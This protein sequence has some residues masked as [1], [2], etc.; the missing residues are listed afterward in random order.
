MSTTKSNNPSSPKYDISKYL[1]SKHMILYFFGMI[2]LVFFL[3]L[4]FWNNLNYILLGLIFFL[5]M[6][7]WWLIFDYKDFTKKTVLQL[8]LI[9]FVW[10]ASIAFVT[11]LYIWLGFF[12]V[13]LGIFYALYS[14]FRYKHSF[15]KFSLWSYAMHG[16]FYLAYFMW[17]GVWFFV[18]WNYNIVDFNCNKIYGYYSQLTNIFGMDDTPPSRDIP[19]VTI[20]EYDLI[21]QNED[22]HKD[23]VRAYFLAKRNDIK[24]TFNA[25]RNEFV[26]DVVEQRKII[27]QEFCEISINQINKLYQ[28]DGIKFGVIAFMWLFLYPFF[29][30]LFYI[31]WF[32]S[33]LALKLLFFTGVWK[34][35]KKTDEITYVW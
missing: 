31:Y 28:S 16:L 24:S 26:T 13:N 2:Y 32:V 18:I 4:L 6:L 19:V 5:T 29:L 30:I 11:N 25:Y 33:W 7:I 1:D 8:I 14:C 17:F 34:Y 23:E 21:K 9:L 15:R 20:Y 35:K 22:L 12:V 3:N 10:S 27:N